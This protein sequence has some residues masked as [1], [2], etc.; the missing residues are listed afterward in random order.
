MTNNLGVK[1]SKFLAWDVNRLR[2]LRKNLV[3][4]GQLSQDEL[5]V[6]DCLI[7]DDMAIRAALEERPDFSKLYSDEVKTIHLDY[8]SYLEPIFNFVDENCTKASDNITPLGQIQLERSEMVDILFDF[9]QELD[10][11]W[12]NIFYKLYT[13]DNNFIAFSNNPS[14]SMYTPSTWICNVNENGTMK[15]CSDLAHEF[16]HGIQDVISNKK[17]VYS[18]ETVLIEM[19]PMLMQTLFV[20]YL[21]KHGIETEQCNLELMHTFNSIINE[22]GSLVTKFE[23][24][25]LLPNISNARNLKRVIIRELGMDFSQEDLISLFSVSA[26]RE[27]HYVLPYIV[28]MNLYKMYQEDKDLFIRNVN[29]LLNANENMVE[30]ATELKIM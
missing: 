11:N 8:Y 19:F 7:E 13:D 23:I 26:K 18:P 14:F 29:K 20:D 16:G 6:I 1:N 24:T 10:K 28:A 21:K 22:A 4:S 12:F 25:E 3:K 15:E 9:F 30:V 2:D 5:S 27:M 17:N